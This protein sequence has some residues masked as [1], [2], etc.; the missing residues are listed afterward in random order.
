M[1]T[2]FSQMKSDTHPNLDNAVAS[3]AQSNHAAERVALL[4]SEE[5]K[6]MILDEPS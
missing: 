6:Q 1:A 4:G 5:S 2:D 3:S